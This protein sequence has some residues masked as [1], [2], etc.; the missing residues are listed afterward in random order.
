M[1]REEKIKALK[2]PDFRGSEFDNPVGKTMKDLSDE[3]L[4]NIQGASDVSQDT[5]HINIT[6]KITVAVSVKFCPKL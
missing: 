5:S 3:E 2:N 1:S 4:E 6:T